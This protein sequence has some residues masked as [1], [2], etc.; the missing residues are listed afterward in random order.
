MLDEIVART[1]RTVGLT[2]LGIAVL[3]VIV[4]SVVSPLGDWSG[5]DY[6]LALL[7]LLWGLAFSIAPRAGR[8]TAV[9]AVGL[10]LGAIVVGFALSSLE[11]PVVVF[12]LGILIGAVVLVIG[13][14]IVNRQERA[15]R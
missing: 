1:D 15:A 14:I 4:A 7:V 3:T 6:F 12:A 5:S 13:A 11:P 10:L 2:T 8:S 9:F